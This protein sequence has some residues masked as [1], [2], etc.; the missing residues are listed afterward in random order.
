MPLAQTPM[1]RRRDLDGRT[2]EAR[3]WRRGRAAPI[4]LPQE[5]LWAG[6]PPRLAR[7]RRSSPPR[8]ARR[9]GPSGPRRVAPAPPFVAPPV[10][11]Y[12]SSSAQLAHV[13]RARP[14]RCHHLRATRRRDRAGPAGQHRRSA[15]GRAARLP[16][17]PA[18]LRRADRLTARCPA[19]AASRA[20]SRFCDNSHVE[21]GFTASG[22]GDPRPDE[23]RE[24]RDGPVEIVPS[25]TDPCGSTAAWRSCR[26]RG[27]RCR[28]PAR[29]VGAAA[30]I[31]GRSRSATDRMWRQGS[32]RMA[33][34][35]DAPH[36][37]VLLWSASS[38]K[39]TFTP[40]T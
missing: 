10:L 38:R 17:R 29:F 33:S 32:C 27:I 5:S 11:A 14:L 25:G 18:P 31:R 2:A 23:P 30:G 7:R 37:K 35:E 26:A 6:R 28:T 39:T 9:T 4:P 16:R 34:E 21:A 13:R 22:E 40:G 3:L 12:P 8:G 24:A 36:P 20:T 19:A 15:R 1:R